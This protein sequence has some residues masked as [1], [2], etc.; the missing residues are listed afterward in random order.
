MFELLKLVEAL[1]APLNIVL[2]ALAGGSVLL[3]FEK[4]RWARRL[5]HL[6]LCMMLALAFLPW[7]SWLIAPLENR[8]P[9]PAT[10]P[11]QVDGIIV[12]GGAI[13]PVLSEEHGQPAIRA[14]GERLFALVE[15]ARRFPQARVIYTGGSGSAV[16]Q[17]AKDAPVAQALLESIGV[18]RGR[19]IFEAESRNTWE[20]AELSRAMVRPAPEETWLLVTS[21]IHMPRSVGVFRAAGWPVTAYPVDYTNLADYG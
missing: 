13:D 17:D 4:A 14:S 5:L 20:N 3:A 12:L 6:A 9:A 19:V 18:D 15:L 10:L 7:E 8:F 21:A 2:L 11:A 1:T 16:R